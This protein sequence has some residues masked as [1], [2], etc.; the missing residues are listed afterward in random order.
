LTDIESVATECLDLND[1]WEFRRLLELYEMLDE[2]LLRRLVEHG[3]HSKNPEVRE[4]AE[5][6]G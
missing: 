4:A 2:Q 5:D 3:S 1:E 6:Y